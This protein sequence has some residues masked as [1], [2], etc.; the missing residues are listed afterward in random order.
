M[1]LCTNFEYFQTFVFFGIITMN[2]ARSQKKFSWQTIWDLSE[3]FQ[4]Q[5]IQRSEEEC[6]ILKITII[7]SR[8]VRKC[9]F[10]Y[11]FEY[12]QTFCFLLLS[13]WALRDLRKFFSTNNLRLLRKVL[14]PRDLQI[15]GGMYNSQNHYNSV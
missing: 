3:K 11:N 13:Q 7:L 9:I 15:W 2:P 14:A 5:E 12:F 6:I 8:M 10:M 1:Y 4:L